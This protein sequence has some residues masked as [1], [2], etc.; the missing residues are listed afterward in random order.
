MKEEEEEEDEKRIRTGLKR[1]QTLTGLIER[2]LSLTDCSLTISWVSWRPVDGISCCG[3]VRDKT[4]PKRKGSDGGERKKKE[5]TKNRELFSTP[6][7]F[8][9]KSLLFFAS[10]NSRALIMNWTGSERPFTLST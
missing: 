8:V 9:S 5:N 1:R 7:C 6:T 2:N 3:V 4:T 10:F